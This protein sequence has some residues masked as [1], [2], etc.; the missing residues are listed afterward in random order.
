MC[1]CVHIYMIY[2]EELAIPHNKFLRNMEAEKF[3]SSEVSKLEAWENWW[4]TFQ[5]KGRRSVPQLGDW[6]VNSPFLSLFFFCSGLQWAG[7]KSSSFLKAC[8][9]NFSSLE[10]KLEIVNTGNLA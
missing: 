5:S 3:P 8:S 6:R 4:C 2:F 7:C 10:Q 9:Q 1:V